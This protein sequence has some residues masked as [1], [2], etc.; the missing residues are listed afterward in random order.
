VFA[1]FS[2]H[3]TV[4]RRYE[5]LVFKAARVDRLLGGS[6]GC[7]CLRLE[8]DLDGFDITPLTLFVSS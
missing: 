6:V 1:L 3:P 2:Y 7:L 8:I 4:R 5:I